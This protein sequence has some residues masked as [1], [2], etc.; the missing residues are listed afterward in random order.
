MNRE[1]VGQYAG[2]ATRGIAFVLDLLLIAV[3]LAM[4]SWL[5]NASLALVGVDLEACAPYVFPGS[6]SSFVC[7]ATRVGL[8]VYAVA[9]TPVYGLFFWTL[10]G[11]TPGMN[12]MG[13]RV[14]RTDGRPMTLG[15]SVRRA[16]G[17][18]LCLLTLGIG[19][20]LM[21]VN[22]RRQ[23]LHDKLAGTCVIY[24]WRGEQNVATIE[25]VRRW[26]ERR[27]KPKNSPDSA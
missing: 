8:A 22:D 5:V 12:V 14:V 24:A 10:G 2:A 19:F 23:G 27:T 26:M 16:L 9:F 6:L 15:R 13:I 11:Q 18:A 4:T 3:I 25:R 17:F 1:L 7:N 20:L 21:L